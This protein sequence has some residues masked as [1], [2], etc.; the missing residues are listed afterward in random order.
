VQEPTRG[1]RLREGILLVAYACL[2]VAG[3]WTVVVSELSTQEPA[4]LHPQTVAAPTKN[5]APSGK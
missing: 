3:V 4:P 1:A 5:D 2:F